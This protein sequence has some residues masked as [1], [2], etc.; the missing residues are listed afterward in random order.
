MNALTDALVDGNT[1][2]ADGDLLEEAALIAANATEHE[3]A[4]QPRLEIGFLALDGDPIA[5]MGVAIRWS[6]GEL[7]ARTDGGGNIPPVEAPPGETLSISVQRLDGTYKKI[8]ECRMPSSD[9]VLT[10]VSPNIFFDTIS[11]KHEGDPGSAEDHIPKPAETDLG[12]LIPAQEPLAPSP[13]G[14]DAATVEAEPPQDPVRGAQSPGSSDT[15]SNK[16]II[17]QEPSPK[18]SHGR[19]R[20][21]DRELSI[22]SPKPRQETDRPPQHIAGR[23]ARK[24]TLETR[25][26][27]NGN[28]LAFISEKVLD[29]WNSW[30]LPTSN[31]WGAGVP[32]DSRPQSQ[33]AG[34]TTPTAN[35]AFNAEMTKK[36]EALLEF[37]R[38]QTEYDYKASG[39]RTATVLA[40][41]NNGTFKHNNGE[42]LTNDA[43]GLCYTYVKIALARC[44]IVDG[45]LAGESASSA[46]P[47]LLGKGFK[48][49]TDEVPDARWAA[50]GDVI[51]YEWTDS[52][53]TKRKK[54]NPSTP[55]YGH[56]D[57]RD[58]EFYISDFIPA[59]PKH[60]GHHPAWVSYQNIRV[61]RK[62]FDPLPTQRIR[63][64]L[65][66]IRDFECQ[67][68]P[69]DKK[70][71]QMLN[72]A[73]P[74]GSR[75]FANYTTHP[76]EG[77]SKPAKG[78]TAAGAYQTIHGTWKE[79]FDNGLIQSQGDQFSPEIQDRIAVMKLED[80]GV[81]HL[82]RTGRIEEAVSG[83]TSE[84]TSLPGG[85]ENAH[86]LT[87]EK[88]QMN[89][90][91]FSR[92][93]DKYLS[94]EKEK[95]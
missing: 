94:M 79:V 20:N 18:V 53:W 80:R 95:A 17:A 72:A 35:V 56:I 63:A 83:L 22:S 57:I 50:A 55:N 25:R 10:T 49:V 69:D 31:L 28:P 32:S 2:Q 87:A 81:L 75:R 78:S 12:D 47:A 58:Y 54:K 37:A 71:Y 41:M 40:S 9:G 36:V 15:T 74:N 77:I 88:T 27:R 51:V 11:E 1:Q 6:D 68:E 5:K 46:G 91:Y 42:K 62:I 85:K 38:E 66:C 24:P 84:W 14:T 60:P 43:T 30:R 13:V 33:S 7:I 16:V 76:W 70:R 90:N 59:P 61:Y 29:W 65:H 64:F 26:D 3:P 93:F 34:G 48:D 19:E 73:L 86:R 21:H 67:A 89:I 39:E 44:K 52:A 8:G 4:G 45:M 23:K 92:Q 82:V